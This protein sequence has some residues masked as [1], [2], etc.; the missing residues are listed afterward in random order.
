MPNEEKFVT[1]YEGEVIKN[2]L[3]DHEERITV[4]ERFRLMARGALMVI[5]AILGTGFGFTILAYM[6]GMI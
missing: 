5:S 3:N 1:T 4:N 6:I 2:K